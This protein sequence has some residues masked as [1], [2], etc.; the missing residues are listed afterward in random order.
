MTSA[1]A[2]WFL[3]R[4]TGLVSLL[5][6]TA[7]IVIGVASSLRVAGSTTPRFVV[8]GL[9]RNV[10]LLTV[11]FIV[12]HV[13]TTIL[14]AYA[15]IRLVDAVVPFISSYRPIW[16]GLGALAF[17]L[18]LAVIITSLVRVRIGL[19]T[20]RGIHF[21]AY[22]CFP[23]AAVHSLGT[24][25]DASQ[26]WM[27]AVLI[28]CVG[29][30]A[31]A[32]LMRL[33]QIR[34]ERAPLALAG[35]AMV[36]VLPLA[37]AAWANTGPLSHGWAARAGTPTNLV[38]S[39]TSSTSSS[40][41]TKPATSGLPAPPYTA[42]ITGTISETTPDSAGN[43]VVTISAATTG[44]AHAHL[45]IVL[46]GISNGSGGLTQMTGNSATFGPAST[47]ALYSGSVVSLQGN[48]V[49]ISFSTT[50]AAPAQ[51]LVN[52]TLQINFSAGTITGQIQVS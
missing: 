3:T 52:T 39:K 1:H 24:G 36:I 47:P 12:V 22:A 27:L 5:L 25:S 49:D 11:A 2:L 13:V 15:P 50:S 10:S 16:L 17:D 26:R 37:G 19:R 28:V 48:Q 34:S 18:T 44:S 9:H 7:S 30:V 8:A 29:I 42:P 35:T 38:G 33:W 40:T 31:A 14:D 6:V 51:L 4:G 43:T 23:I 32:T 21:L 20:W 46:D 41:P 45:K